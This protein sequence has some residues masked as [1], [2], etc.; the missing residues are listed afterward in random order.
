M[1]ESTLDQSILYFK[2]II[3]LL[4][5]IKS[6][7]YFIIWSCNEFYIQSFEK[8][9]QQSQ[10]CREYLYDTNRIKD[11]FWAVPDEQL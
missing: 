11:A 7:Q 9:G 8:L 6:I 2:N 10:F 4:I 5:I 3:S 1:L